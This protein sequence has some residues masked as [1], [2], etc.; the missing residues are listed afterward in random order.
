MW[1][2][3]RVAEKESGLELDWYLEYFVNSTKY[4][5]Y[6]LTDVIEDEEET[7]IELERKGK[8]FMPVD[9]VVTRFNGEK[10]MHHIPLGVMRG[11][12]KE[13]FDGEYIVED[14]WFWTNKSYT[15]TLDLPIRSIMKVEIDPS[16]RLADMDREN[17]SQTFTN[18]R[19]VIRSRQKQVK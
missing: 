18:K 8:M 11:S 3:I 4:V 17:N 6:E 9:V 19:A 12:K 14:D 7:I 10:I 2:F 13:N 1:D 16:G 15:L 5:D